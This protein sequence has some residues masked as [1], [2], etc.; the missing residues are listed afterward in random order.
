M[1]IL[2]VE[3]DPWVGDGVVTALKLEQH[4]VD[5]VQDGMAALHAGQY[6]PFDIIIL[7]LGLPR[8]DGVEVIRQLR[9]QHNDTPI[10]VLTARDQLAQKI[11]ALDLGADDYLLKPFDMD[12]LQARLRAIVRRRHGQ[13][14]ATLNYG[15]I[16]INPATHDVTYQQQAVSLNR[17]EFSLLVEFVQHAGQVLSRDHLEQ[18]LYSWDDEIESNALQVHVHHLR[19]K[20]YPELIRTIRGV[21]YQLPKQPAN[22][23]Q[24]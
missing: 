14:T 12:E 22:E 10:L 5:W 19:K 18:L 7:D 9:Q 3:D 13:A 15:A 11:Q 2:L 23:D 17:R 21:G 20:F 16:E 4:S 8:L 1:R 6:H 24:L